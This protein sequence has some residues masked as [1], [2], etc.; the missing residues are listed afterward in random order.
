MSK[1][2]LLLF[3]GLF[4]SCKI[5]RSVVELKKEKASVHHYEYNGK[6]IAYLPLHHVGKPS[7]YA[8]VKNKITAYKLQG[9]KV[10]YELITTDIPGDSLQKDII[11]RKV[12]KIK[13]TNKDY[14]QLADETTIFKNYVKQPAYADLGI[15]TTRVFL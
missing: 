4:S 5:V 3:L 9:Y 2:I 15:D 6:E 7:F 14:K 12:R 10:Y 11:R 8:D 13:G 1:Y